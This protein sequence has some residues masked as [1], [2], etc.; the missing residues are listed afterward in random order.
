M[1]SIKSNL[2]LKRSFNQRDS[3]NASKTGSRTKKRKLNSVKRK[4]LNIDGTYN[5]D[6]NIS[7]SSSIDHRNSQFS[8]NHSSTNKTQG[9]N[10]D[11]KYKYKYKYK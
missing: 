3:P 7:H 2:P 11:Y 1:S 6:S 8:K 5:N 9:M 10:I 4:F